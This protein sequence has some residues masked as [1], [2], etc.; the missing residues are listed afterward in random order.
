METRDNT[1]GTSLASSARVS[2][3]SSRVVMPFALAAAACS[4]TACTS[5][6]DASSSTPDPVVAPAPDPAPSESE[7]D[8]Q[9]ALCAAQTAKLQ[10]GLDKAH[11]KDT[12][13]VIA[14]KNASC[15]MRVLLSGPAKIDKTHLHRVGS[16]T[17]TYVAAVVLT[18]AKDGALSLDDKVSKW[19]PDLAGGDGI[20]VRQ[21]L[22]HSS[23]LFNYTDDQTFRRTGFLKVWTP[24]QLVS[25]AEA[26]PVYFE[27]G[28]GWHYSNTNYILLGM[29]AEGAG[30]AKI[31]ALVR[32][33]VLTKA[34]LTSTFFD[35][36]EPV[37]GT[38]AP[39]QGTTGEDVTKFADPSWAWAAG[40]IV[41]TP[42]D[43]TSWIEMLGSGA[44]HDPA[45]QQQL[46]TP[47]PTDDKSLGYGLGIMLFGRNITAGGG[48]G[49]GHGGDIPGYHTQ[50]FYF[51]EKHT[52]LVS[53]V[54]SDA[55][56]S[57]D[58]SIAALDV[59]F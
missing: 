22:N 16:V 10:A 20:S 42:E 31:G 47:F 49:I 6:T 8:P 55:E 58:V 54:D 15:G 9:I 52:T 44:F 19:V 11:S 1:Q 12:E 33:R 41:A 5:S 3:I 57:N 30:K 38:M 14:V 32:A 4:V 25:V 48:P 24:R 26:N 2:L 37:A 50:A 34:G 27:P 7:P 51:P 53:I 45:M 36:E 29:I 23:G 13:A 17:K 56:S 59:L 28:K 43:V 18:L 21:L 35:G 46:L 39:G 40:A